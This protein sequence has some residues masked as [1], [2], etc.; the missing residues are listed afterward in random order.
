MFTAGL[1]WQPH[2]SGGVRI[3]RHVYQA[4]YQPRYWYSLH[5][6]INPIPKMALEQR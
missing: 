2:Y 4:V 1:P 6:T 5:Q 3:L